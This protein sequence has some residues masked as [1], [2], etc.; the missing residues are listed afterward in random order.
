MEPENVL[1]CSEEPTNELYSKPAESSQYR[2]SICLRSILILSYNLR[3]DLAAGLSY[4]HSHQ[5]P[6]C[7]L[8]VSLCAT[9]PSN[10][11]LDLV[12]LI[13]FGEEHNLWSSSLC[14]F[15]FGFILFNLS[16]VQIF[17]SVPSSQIP[18]VYVPSLVWETKFH[19]HTEL[20]VKLQFLHFNLSVFWT[21]DE[22]KFFEVC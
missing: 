12:L 1:P 10:L 8:L 2:N 20:Q 22:K 9:F 5:N 18:S 14:I 3:L 15:F 7:S 6:M 4:R 11:I 13:I 16:P 17:S 21:T 19:I